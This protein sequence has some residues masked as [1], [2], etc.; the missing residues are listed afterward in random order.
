M[1]GLWRTK[2]GGPKHVHVQ[3]SLH[4]AVTLLYIDISEKTYIK[5]SSELKINNTGIANNTK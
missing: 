5:E 2:S 1:M 4:F 3:E